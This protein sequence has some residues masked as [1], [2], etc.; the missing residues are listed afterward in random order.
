MVKEAY[1]LLKATK[2][3][4][5]HLTKCNHRGPSVAKGLIHKNKAARHKATRLHRSNWLNRPVCCRF[6]KNPRASGY[7]CYLIVFFSLATDIVRSML[8][9]LFVFS[10]IPSVA[11]ILEKLFSSLVFYFIIIKPQLHL[12]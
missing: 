3:N 8:F 4:G 7:A 9:Q 1:V 10:A 11:S 12:S 6:V 2:D 5:K